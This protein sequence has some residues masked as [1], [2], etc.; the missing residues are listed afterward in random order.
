MHALRSL[1]PTLNKG[2]FDNNGMTANGLV[3]CRPTHAWSKNV[4]AVKWQSR[5]V[6]WHPG[7]DNR[8]DDGWQAV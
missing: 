1:S 7:G 8:G 5:Y 3:A 4:R 6:D 2:I